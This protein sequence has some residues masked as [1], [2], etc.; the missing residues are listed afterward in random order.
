MLCVIATLQTVT[1][2]M[3]TTTKRR[4]FTIVWF[5]TE[6]RVDSSKMEQINAF[7]KAT[8]VKKIQL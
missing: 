6:L 1:V 3:T 8:D 5:L 4:T 2:T 7:G